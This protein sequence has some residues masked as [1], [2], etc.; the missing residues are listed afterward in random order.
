MAAKRTIAIIATVA[1]L[2]AAVY[3]FYQKKA[4]PAPPE[5]LITRD[6]IHPEPSIVPHPHPLQV[7][8]RFQ[9]N[10]ESQKIFSEYKCQKEKCNLSP[11]LAETEEEAMWLKARGYPSQIQFEE[12]KR[13]PTSELKLR[14]RK[15]DLA[16]GAL[17][18]ERLMEEGNWNDSQIELAGTA[19]RGSIYALYG[20]SRRASE[21]PR[22]RDPIDA[23]AWIRAAYLAGDYKSTLQLVKTH[24]ERT[25]PN[26]QVYVDEIAAHR[27]KMIM[28]YRSYP[29]PAK[30]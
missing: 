16:Y 4:V 30:D 6:A 3:F 23:K 14:A 26:E 27:F 21:N 19:M 12:A 22:F 13:L 20:L 25:D 2:A 28:K 8:K 11:F 24:P 29:R 10:P 1:S 5:L 9:S 17:Y 15:G 18:G 7:A